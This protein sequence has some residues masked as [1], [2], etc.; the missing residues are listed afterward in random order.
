LAGY[1]GELSKRKKGITAALDNL[2][3]IVEGYLN[4]T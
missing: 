4:A 1:I 2:S 3:S